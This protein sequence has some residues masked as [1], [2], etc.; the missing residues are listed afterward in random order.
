MEQNRIYDA[1]MAAFRRNGVKAT[2][3]GE[4]AVQLRISKR[5]LYELCHDKQ[6]LLR[7]CIRREVGRES[8]WLEKV[9]RRHSASPLR[10]IVRIYLHTIRYANSFNPVFFPELSADTYFRIV[11]TGYYRL[12]GQ[13][14]GLLLRR[15]RQA[16]LCLP[17]CTDR[18]LVDF[19]CQRFI[20]IS[21]GA[22]APD[23]AAPELS[24]FIVRAVLSGICTQAG[25]NELFKEDSAQQ[26]ED[27]TQLREVFRCI[28]DK[29]F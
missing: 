7:R 24:G 16:D 27:I 10:S 2:N 3:M 8:L 18:T 9:V 11:W 14:Y 28:R 4:L 29:S 13:K 21:T 17:D 5:T 23:R 15:C 6:T 1:A 26:I 22:I 25:L 19:L 12:L 20:E